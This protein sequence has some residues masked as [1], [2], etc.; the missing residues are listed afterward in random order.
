MSTPSTMEAPWYIAGANQAASLGAGVSGVP[1]FRDAKHD[2]ILALMAWVEEQEAPDDIIA[3]V[4]TNDQTQTEVHRQ[5]PICKYPLRAKYTGSGDGNSA[6][7][8]SCEPLY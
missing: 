2:V 4:W 3:T 6:D 5:R 7:S 1:G 8:W